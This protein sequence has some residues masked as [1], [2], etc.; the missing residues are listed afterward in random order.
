MAKELQKEIS[1][2]K[3]SGEKPL[4][5]LILSSPS[6]SNATGAMLNPDELKELCGLCEEE[7]IQFLSDEIYHGISYGTEEATA[8]QFSSKALIINSF[9]KYYS[10][11]QARVVIEQ[12]EFSLAHRLFCICSDSVGLEVGLDGD[13]RIVVGCHQ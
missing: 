13:S 7:K 9:S 6:I 11:K 2:R 4:K 12:I 8:L 10:T 3:E 5:G 1:R